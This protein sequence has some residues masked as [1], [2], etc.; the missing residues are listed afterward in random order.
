LPILVEDTIGLARFREK[1][2]PLMSGEAD[3]AEQSSRAAAAGSPEGRSVPNRRFA[4]GR[5]AETG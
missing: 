3:R 1:Y 5:R 4:R 2:A